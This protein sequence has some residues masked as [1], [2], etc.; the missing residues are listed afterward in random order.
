MTDEQMQALLRSNYYAHLAC[1]G[2]DGLYLVPITYFYENGMIYSYTHDGKKIDILRNQ[3][4]SVCIQTENIN[5][6]N[7]WESVI[8]WGTFEE[9]YDDEEEKTSLKIIERFASSEMEN[10]PVCCPLIGDVTKYAN[11]PKGTPITYRIKITK[12]TGKMEK[13]E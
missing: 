1:N 5:S 3:N 7:D 2:N 9:V 10:K 4:P 13:P 6:P 11:N 8:C 12:M